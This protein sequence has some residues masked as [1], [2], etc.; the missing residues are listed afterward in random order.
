MHRNL[1]DNIAKILEVLGV[2]K[3]PFDCPQ[4]GQT[5]GELIVNMQLV[6]LMEAKTIVEIGSGTGGNI[7]MLSAALGSEN[8][9]KVITIDPW[10]KNT[11]YYEQYKVYQSTINE[12]QQHFNNITYIC[13][14][15]HSQS[16]EALKELKAILNKN[17]E[18]IDFL[19]IDGDHEQHKVES[20]FHNFRKLVSSQGIICF[21]DTIGDSGVAAAW[22]IFLNSFVPPYSFSEVI[23]EGYPLLPN[24][25]ITQKLGLGYLYLDD[26][27][28][29]VKIF[30]KSVSLK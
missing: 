26:L 16:P 30:L 22:K 9:H 18:L 6:R 23:E 8:H 4:I 29:K 2:Q 3:L 21:H 24:A 17:N 19:F 20:D 15:H 13:I 14:K 5:Q 12:L 1:S 7:S 27:P 10:D 25:Y 28:N 11:K